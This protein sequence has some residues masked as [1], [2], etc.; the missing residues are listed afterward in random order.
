LTTITNGGLRKAHKE[1]IVMNSAQILF[2]AVV[3]FIPVILFVLGLGLIS[4]ALE[5]PRHARALARLFRRN[6]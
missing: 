5:S 2:D 1:S 4:I 6:R 3:E